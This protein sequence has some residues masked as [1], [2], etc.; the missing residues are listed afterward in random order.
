MVLFQ[1][2]QFCGEANKS[3][4]LTLYK[5][6]FLC[7]KLLINTDILYF[8]SEISQNALH[9]RVSYDIHNIH[10]TYQAKNYMY[11]AVLTF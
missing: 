6:I 2:Q 9:V 1:L 3:E 5:A 4:K 8:N 11:T 7:S 10:Y